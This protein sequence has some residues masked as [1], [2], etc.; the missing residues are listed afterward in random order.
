MDSETKY[1][2]EARLKIVEDH[3]VKLSSEIKGFRIT[4]ESTNI[5]ELIKRLNE[6]TDTLEYIIKQIE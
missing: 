5:F 3:I 4:N 1:I 2:I 6:S